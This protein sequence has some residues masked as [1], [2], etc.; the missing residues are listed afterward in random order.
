MWRVL[1]TIVTTEKQQRVAELR[2]AVKKQ[3]NK[4]PVLQENVS[5]VSLC[6]RQ[7]QNVCRSL[8]RGPDIFVRP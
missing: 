6:S 5:M 7:Q 4:H 3:T 2:V 1:V 8:R